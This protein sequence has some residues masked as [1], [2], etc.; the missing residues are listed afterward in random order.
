MQHVISRYTPVVVVFLAILLAIVA[1]FSLHNAQF[2]HAETATVTVSVVWYECGDGVDNDFDGFTDYPNDPGCTDAGDDDETDPECVDGVDN[3]GDGLIDFPDDLGCID[4]ND[5]D[6]VN[7]QCIDGIDNDLDGFIDY[8]A[9]LGCSNAN[10]NDE[11][12]GTPPDSGTGASGGRVDPNAVFVSFEGLS[13]PF[14]S[15]FLLQDGVRIGEVTAGEDA[16]FSLKLFRVTPG[17]YVYTLYG[18]DTDG[19]K[20]GLLSFSA[21][22]VPSG[23]VLISDIYIPPTLSLVPGASG[24]LVRGQTVPQSDLTL[25]ASERGRKLDRVETGVDVNGRFTYS[26][27]PGTITNQ[28]IVTA[29]SVFGGLAS[30]FGQSASLAENLFSGSSILGDVNSD[31]RVNIVDFSIVVF[32]YNRENAPAQLDINADGEVDLSDISIMAFYWTG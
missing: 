28:S 15:V 3:D 29:R 31:R 32:W 8:P 30:P 11:S 6:E 18:I 22:I 10:D 13:H 17:I 14:G 9:D 23:S 25:D 12:G 4:A 5:T 16:Q 19:V 24:Y 27:L 20:S 7:P 1:A 26:F 21:E 2:I